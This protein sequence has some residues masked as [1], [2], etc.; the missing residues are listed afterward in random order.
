MNKGRLIDIPYKDS[1][2][3]LFTYRQ[4]ASLALGQYSFTTT[5][6]TKAA[7]NPS[8]PIRGNTLY[9][10]NTL[11]FAMDIAETDYQGAI[12]T[13]PEFSMYLQ[14]N[15]T[16]PQLREPI[17]LAKYFDNVPYV[18]TFLGTELLSGFGNAA[19]G[20]S[21]NRLLGTVNGVLNQTASLVGKASVTAI[22]T[23]SA[24]EVVDNEFIKQFLGA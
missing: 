3:I 6:M 4:T 16:A 17:V 11:T 2:P 8:R 7:F 5:P 21:F 23:L 12:A 14:S 20:Y 13:Q 9:V 22:V 24:Q 1:P 18:L 19:Q 15:A 10:F